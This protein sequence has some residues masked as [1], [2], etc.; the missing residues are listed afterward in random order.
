[1]AI[2]IARGTETGKQPDIFKT[3][4][5]I[6]ETHT[7][8]LVI[9]LCG[10]IGSPLHAVS[11]TL[12]NCLEH[13]FKYENCEIIK[14]SDLIREH[15]K[16]PVNDSSEFHRVSSLIEAGNELRRAH[17]SGILA[18][19]AVSKISRNR[20]AAAARAGEENPKPRRVCHIIDSVKN[21]EEFD[22]LRDVY[23]EML[24]FVGVFSPI[25]NRVAALSDGMTTSEV[26]QLIDRD[27]GEEIDHGQTVRD[28]FPQAD[29]FLRIDNNTSVQLKRKVDRFLDLVLGTK[30]ITPSP[31]ETAMYLAASAANNS[32][33]L[34]RQVGAALTDNEDEILALGWNDVPKRGGGLYVSDPNNDPSG[35]RDKRCWNSP[36]RCENDKEKDVIATLAV[37]ELV[38]AGVLQKKDVEKATKL[39][40]KNS[41][42]KGLIEFSRAVHAE[43]HAL[44]SAGKKNGHR[45]QGGKLYCTTY[46]CHSC[47]RHL[48][49]A[50]VSEVYYIEPYRKSLATRLHGDAITEDENDLNKVRI[51]PYEGVAPSRYLGLFR[52]KPDSRKGKED[53]KVRTGTRED[54]EPK[55]SKSIEALT[56]LEG[57]VVKSLKDR[58]VIDLEGKNV[59][60]EHG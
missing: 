32:A 50:G 52:M 23:R 24:Y 29:F 14:L 57:I 17:G 10:P 30:I 37:N 41:K 2:Q 19:L 51:L 11:E 13:E 47:A 3:L 27:S 20:E 18:E 45:I 36:G 28:T 38:T 56:A 21:Q 25:H 54:A 46:P 35:E 33:C 5:K 6:K 7:S 43:M 55:I 59:G 53:G 48:I 12:K 34:S 1:M 16:T 8:E 22:I 9:A 60:E 58:N 39:F 40:R 42:L 4:P 44:I 31:G 49:A 15:A 26:Y